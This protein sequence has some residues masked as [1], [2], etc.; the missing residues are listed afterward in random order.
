M[1]DVIGVYFFGFM[2]GGVYIFFICVY[3]EDMDFLVCVYYVSYFCFMEWGC[4]EL[5][6]V[7]E[8]VQFDF[9]VS[10]DGFVFVVCKMNIDFFGGVVMDD[11]FIIVICFKEMCGV[12]MMF[13][14]EVC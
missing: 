4:M 1:R 12:L 13:V 8:V 6:W 11:V 5:L 2:Q 10:M 9:Y 7:V 3:Y 14:Q